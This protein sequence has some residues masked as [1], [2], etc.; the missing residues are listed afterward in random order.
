MNKYRERLS[1]VEGLEMWEYLRKV[2]KK[3][4]HNHKDDVEPNKKKSYQLLN[5]AVVETL[6]HFG[7]RF[8]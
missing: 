8:Q 6:K 5:E 2:Y 3:K 1:L 7:I 4:R